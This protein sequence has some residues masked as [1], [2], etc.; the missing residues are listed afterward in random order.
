MRA[1]E[2]FTLC[3]K[4]N[5]FALGVLQTKAL[6]KKYNEMYIDDA[7]CEEVS[8]QSKLTELVTKIPNCVS[9]QQE[10]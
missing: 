5:L 10:A 2:E 3:K 6:L 8:D 4:L 7:S 1:L 9:G